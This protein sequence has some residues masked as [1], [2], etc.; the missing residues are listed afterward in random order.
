MFGAKR[1]GLPTG[2]NDM[3]RRAT[4]LDHAASTALLPQARTAI[5]DVL[6]LTGNPSSVHA[7]GRALRDRVET[8]RD[9][10]ARLAGAERRHV[11]FTG[12]ATEAITQAIVGG[13]PAL[14]IDV[15]VTSAGE[16]AAVLKAAAASGAAVEAVAL[17][18]D[19]R[20]DTA[21]FEARLSALESAGKTALV[22]VHAVNNET[23]VVQPVAEIEARA[24]AGGHIVFVDAVQAAGKLPLGFADRPAHMMALS[25]HKLGGPAGVG[26][27]LVKP[28][29]DGVR[30]IPGGG[31]EQGRR[32]GTESAPL[33]AG[34]GAAADA[35]PA[36]FDRAALSALARQVEDGV[37]GIDPD[38]VV[39]GAGAECLGTIVNFAVPGLKNS[40]AMMGLDLEG[41]SISSGSACSSGKVGRSHVLE[42]MGVAPD[43][44][45]GALRVSL[46]WPSR[47][48]D[49]S[50]FLAAMGTVVDRRRNAKG[51][52]A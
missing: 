13:M 17:L 30:L 50:A 23:G 33:I 25:A 52:A 6:A 40:V 51:R 22:A 24:E 35:F 4:Y 11:V 34:F 18:P 9:Q 49:V 46:G 12:S 47:S 39:F 26:A 2:N 28:A 37:R 29:C 36:A 7:H 45:D 5:T 20:I 15:V 44:A 1:Q 10:V 14:G 31:Q 42:A 41:V 27:L 38:V 3:T 43:I 8:A 32:G 48:E 16:H 19:G 21:D